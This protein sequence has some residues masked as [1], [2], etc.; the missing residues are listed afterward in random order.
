LLPEYGVGH[1]ELVRDIETRAQRLG[2]LV[3]AGSAYRGVG[4]PDCVATGE[5]GAESV[6]GYMGR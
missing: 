6:F 2:G 4:I 1:L 5:A 3:F